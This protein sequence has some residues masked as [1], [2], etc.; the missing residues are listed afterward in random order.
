MSAGNEDTIRALKRKASE[1]LSDAEVLL[2]RGSEEAVINRSYYA[3]FS[4]A[5]AALLLKDES[6]NTHAGVIR[7]FG[8]HFVRTGRISEEIGDILT[9]AESMR[10]DADYDAFSAFD[11]KEAAQLYQDAHRFVEIVSEQLLS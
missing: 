6:P 9:T 11:R 3:V 7:W 4:T 1:A 5:R 10:G 8:Y 2:E